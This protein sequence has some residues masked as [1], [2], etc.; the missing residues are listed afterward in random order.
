ME[1]RKSLN[2]VPKSLNEVLKGL[3][4]KK[5]KEPCPVCENELYFNDE[6][7][8]KCALIDENNLVLGWICPHC[9]SEFDND[10]NIVEIFTGI[11]GKGE[12]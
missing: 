6:L 3:G 11:E 10:N 12:S 9:R 1:R 8:N 5:S 4:K 7:S 2:P